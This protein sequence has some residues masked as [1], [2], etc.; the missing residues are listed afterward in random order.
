[1]LISRQD[2]REYNDVR[3]A[4]L[5]ILY[6][7]KLEHIREELNRQ[8][9]NEQ[10]LADGH[11]RQ[12]QNKPKEIR[13]ALNVTKKEYRSLIEQNQILKDKLGKFLTKKT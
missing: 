12:E 2:Y 9:E 4:E 8:T 5:E 11:N 7:A 1:M 13:A 6:K 10:E 3:I